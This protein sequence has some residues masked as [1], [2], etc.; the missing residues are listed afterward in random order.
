MQQKNRALE[1]N[2]KRHWEAEMD[3]TPTLTQTTPTN[4][5]Q[6][7]TKISKHIHTLRRDYLYDFLSHI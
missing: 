2:A 6:Y 1:E 3:L 5:K 4:S 7:Q